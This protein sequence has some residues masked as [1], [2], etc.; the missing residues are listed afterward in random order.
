V[1]LLASL[2]GWKE[3]IVMKAMLLF[4]VYLCAGAAQ[5]LAAQKP[6]DT[7]HSSLT[8]H[9]GKAGLFSA[10]GHEHV[11]TAPVAGGSLDDGSAPHVEFRVEA[12][13]L[14]VGPEEHQSEVQQ[15]MQEEVLQSGKFPEIRFASDEIKPTG[16]GVWDVAGKLTL[17]GETRP[18]RLQVRFAD[19]TYMGSVTI[20]QT[21]FGIQPVSAGGGT[22]KVKDEL[23]ID[24]AIK[25][26]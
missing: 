25:T 10:A 21:D 22:V 1:K 13:R 8:I 26:K 12:A 23:K 14:M 19:R 6:L 11:I 9:V 4:G 2:Q 3:E 5:V 15:R 7:E 24:F 17:R 16:N 20:K 18:V